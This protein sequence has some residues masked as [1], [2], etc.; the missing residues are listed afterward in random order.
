MANIQVMGIGSPLVDILIQVDEEFMDS[1]GG[2]KGGMVL[3]ENATITEILNRSKAPFEQAP[4]G[5]AAN[6]IRG[7]AKLGLPSGFVGKV[8]R[9]GLAE[10]LEDT[11]K[12]N[13]VTPL[14][15][16]GNGETGRVLSM[17]TPD[18]QRT[19]RTYLG[20]SLELGPADISPNEFKNAEIVHV[21]GYLLFNRDL[22]LAVLKAAKEAGVRVS[23]DLASFEV[24][25]AAKDILPD[26]L[27]NYVD[28][29]FA[30]EDE[31]FAFTGKAEQESLDE[32]AKLC[33]LAAVKVGKDGAY[34][35]RG[36]LVC[37]V[38]A[39]EAHVVDTTGAGDL[40]ASGF[41]YG[42]IRGFELSRC[43]YMGSLLA[44]KVIENIGASIT[45]KGW[46]EIKLALSY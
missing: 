27:K 4:G 36:D 8:G 18:S 33:E 16:R 41:L 9:D 12:K 29:V 32:L 40:W 25:N 6:T 20:A 15:K 35:K 1:I 38:E 34:L 43:G 2:D 45:E 7:L 30:N 42:I 31:A 22:I 11:F 19:M 21:E 17:V 28:I 3:V 13:G 37:K 46:A 14:L 5:S 10:Y 39:C 26:I 23:L 24:V 44:S